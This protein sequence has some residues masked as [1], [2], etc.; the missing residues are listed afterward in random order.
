LD[1][2]GNF[3]PLALGGKSKRGL[4][5]PGRK[6]KGASGIFIRLTF[7]KSPTPPG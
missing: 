6:L 4:F 1:N 7:A 3:S 5:I 2:A